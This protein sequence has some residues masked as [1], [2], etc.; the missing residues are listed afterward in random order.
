MNR[1]LLLPHKDYFY[2]QYSLS[3][4]THYMFKEVRSRSLLALRRLHFMWFP[5]FYSIWF[6][7]SLKSVDF[8]S[9]DKII[10][11]DSFFSIYVANY[12][13]RKY[14]ITDVSV[15]YRNHIDKPTELKN[16]QAGVKIWSYDK[17]DCK[18]YALKYN[19]QFYFTSI[20]SNIEAEK[21]EYDFFFIGQIK[22]RATIINEVRNQL[23]KRN[24]KL[25]FHVIDETNK[26]SPDYKYLDYKEVVNYIHK[27][28]CVVDLVGNWQTGMTLRPLEALFYKKKLLTN[29]DKIESFDFYSPNN[30][31]VYG[32]DDMSSL[33]QFINS[34][35]DQEK[36]KYIDEY[37][38]PNWL[39]RF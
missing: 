3:V 8:N 2:E 35:F 9:I 21:I 5:Y 19:S 25:F 36:L 18:K 24:F 39:S 29:F 10:I 23:E 14:H 17:D 34:P 37:D 26:K 6:S 4:S 11:F 16:A 13:K 27:S 20:V 32:K 15:Y 22:G 28:R 30:V 31:F 1:L 7:D 38:F 33:V 12:L